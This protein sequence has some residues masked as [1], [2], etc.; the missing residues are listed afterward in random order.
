MTKKTNAQKE[1][2]RL[3]EMKRSADEKRW[4]SSKMTSQERNIKDAGKK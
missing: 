4:N 1:N 2:E 3:A